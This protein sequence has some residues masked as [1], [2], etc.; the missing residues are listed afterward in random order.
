V[1][2]LPTRKRADSDARPKAALRITP[3]AFDEVSAGA[4]T[5]P[6]IAT[7]PGQG[8]AARAAY[9]RAQSSS[10]AYIWQ[11]Q[12]AVRKVIDYI[13][14][15][16][17]Q[18]GVTCYQRVGED[19]RRE[20]RDHPAARSLRRPNGRQGG[21]RFIHGLMADFLIYEQA[22]ALKFRPRGSEELVLWRVPA[23]AVEVH[24]AGSYAPELYRVHLRGGEIRDVRPENVLHLAGYDP[25]DPGNGHSRLETL[26]LILTEEATNQAA[27]L[28]RL[29][30]GG[31]GPGWI[32]RPLEADSFSEIAR[33]RFETEWKERSRARKEGEAIDPVLE[34]GMEFHEGSITPKDAEML[35]SRLFTRSEVAS[36]YGVPAILVEGEEGGEGKDREE[37]R[38]QFYA[39]CLPPLLGPIA[40]D[41]NLMILEEEYGADD[42]FFEF[43]LAEKLKGPIEDRLKALVSAAGGPIITRNEGRGIVNLPDKEGGDELITP[44]NVT[45]GGKPSTDVMPPQDPNGPDQEGGPEPEASL[46]GHRPDA[47]ITLERRA[48]QDR[49]RTRYASEHRELLTDH[50]DRQARIW[51]SSK[52]FDLERFNRELADDLEE[53]AKATVEREGGIAAER[54]ATPGGFDLERCEAYLRRGAEEK[55][56]AINQTTANRIEELDDAG[57][58]AAEP[59]EE[60]DPFA[61]S[62][63]RAEEGGLAIATG[64]AAFS[65]AEAGRQSPTAAQRVKT[66]VVMSANSRHPDLS[67]ETVPIDALFSNGGDHPGDPALG[68]EQTARCQCLLEV[69]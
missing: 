24:S 51:R 63:N 22:F 5:F 42:H 58:Q 1:R 53:K 30:S 33:Q 52:K 60:P 43:N 26:R 21:K 15:N 55:A 28:E 50:F 46:N 34:E 59:D 39:D 65:H 18:I 41:L 44:K 48:A 6:L 16:A 9:Q 37:A 68:T 23:W 69:S 36:L 2:L 4:A 11:T 49:R 47:A 25:D 38:T 32:S 40:E 13:A 45:E 35:R 64:L 66:W 14:R 3:G 57:A 56:Q 61:D 17:A 27:N 10:L 31:L 12:P 20:D 19:D 62:E 8:A 54:L 67:G 7:P 29:R